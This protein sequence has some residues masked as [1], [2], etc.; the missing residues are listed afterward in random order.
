MPGE[1]IRP[2][3]QA[4]GYDVEYSLDSMG[5]LGE[6]IDILEDLGW[7]HARRGR[8]RRLFAVRTRFSLHH[9][10]EM[11]DRL[12]FLRILLKEIAKKHG[13]FIT[14]MPKPTTGDWRSGAHINLSMQAVDNPGVNMY[15]GEDGSGAQNRARVGGL[16]ARRGDDRHRLPAPSTPI[17]DWCPRSADSKAAPTPG[18]PRTSPTATNNRS[19]MLRLPQ[20]RLLPSKTGRPICA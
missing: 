11:A 18:R 15:E 4:F 20:S 3:R 19:A 9:L 13:M 17:T 10:L 12:V 7:N 16:M 8:R 1:G 5:F 2:R 14:F 6:M